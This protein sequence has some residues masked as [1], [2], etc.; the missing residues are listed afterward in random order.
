MK[1]SFETGFKTLSYSLYFRQ[2]TV[3]YT[4][5]VDQNRQTKSDR[6]EQGQKPGHQVGSDS[7][8]DLHGEEKAGILNAKIIWHRDKERKIQ[9]ENAQ[10]DGGHMILGQDK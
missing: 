7:Q 8:I 6:K 2:E 1:R 4:Q 10:F 9:T 5:E 3:G